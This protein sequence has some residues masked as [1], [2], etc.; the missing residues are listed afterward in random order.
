MANVYNGIMSG[1]AQK[2]KAVD[3]KVLR[4]IKIQIVLLLILV[5]G[6]TFYYVSGYAAE[7]SRLKAEAV[8]IVRHSNPDT[9]RQIE[10]SEVYAASGDRISVLKGEKDVYYVTINQIPTYVTQAIISIE[11]KKFYQHNGVD[12][13][14]IARA[15]Y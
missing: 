7:V 5:A 15:L 2:T 14:A 8:S 13:T 12:Y 6:V 3:R 4:L 9:F 1:T 10:T 11:D